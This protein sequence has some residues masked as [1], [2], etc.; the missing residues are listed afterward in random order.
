MDVSYDHRREKALLGMAQSNFRRC[1]RKARAG[2]NSTKAVPNGVIVV[3]TFTPLC[4]PD[5]SIM[6]LNPVQCMQLTNRVRRLHIFS[7]LRRIMRSMSR[8]F[9]V[10][11]L[12]RLVRY[13]ST[14]VV[15]EPVLLPRISFSA[16]SCCA[17]NNT[18]CPTWD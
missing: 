17:Y 6:L 16:R 18:G 5:A 7:C 4:W 3:L 14:P 10:F 15:S 8:V 12:A 9:V 11:I 13:S 2:G 1:R